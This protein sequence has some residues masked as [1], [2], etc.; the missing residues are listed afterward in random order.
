MCNRTVAFW[1]KIKKGQSPQRQGLR[2]MG[3]AQVI[4]M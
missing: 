4:D 3:A 1:E 2:R